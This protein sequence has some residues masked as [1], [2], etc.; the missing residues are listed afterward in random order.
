M[1]K[2]KFCLIG[3]V[4]FACTILSAQAATISLRADLWCP[5]TC[6][7]KSDRP[8]FM[9]E[10]AQEIF[11]MNGDT[12]D[13][14]VMNWA[15]AVAETKDGKFD[16]VVGANRGDVPGFVLPE[17]S[18]GANINY[19]WALK[20][21]QFEYKNIDSVKNKKIGV[22]NGYSYGGDELDIP[23]K[24]HHHSFVILPGND[25]LTKIIKMIEAGRIDA[26][27][28]NPYV[29]QNLLKTDL[30]QFQNTLKPVSKNIV[31][32]PELFIAFTPAKTKKETSVKYAKI[33]SD[34]LTKLRKSGRLKVILDKYEIKDW[35]K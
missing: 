35:H 6:D 25:A 14:Q 30:K 16:A 31:T 11:K 19:F 3:I 4:V 17:N 2:Q 28:E 27:V 34:G 23:I 18:S 12:I 9:I 8:G 5:Y 32:D 22:I 10:I 7:P 33:L 26:F 24:N 15:R 20:K 29:L 13:Y 21:S 1:Y